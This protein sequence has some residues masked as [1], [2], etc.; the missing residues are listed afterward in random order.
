VER[1]GGAAVFRGRLPGIHTAKPPSTTGWWARGAADAGS[2]TWWLE[3]LDALGLDGFPDTL[4]HA[5]QEYAVY[6]HATPGERDDGVTLGVHVDQLPMPA[7]GCRSW[8]VDG[9]SAAG[10][11]DDA[12]AAQGLPPRLPAHRRRGG[13]LRRPVARPHRRRA[14]GVRWRVLDEVLA[15]RI[16]PSV[17]D[18]ERLPEPLV[19][20]I[21]VCDDEGGE[22]AMG[23]DVAVLK[24][25]LADRMRARFEAAANSE[26]ERGGM[27][28]WDGEELPES[29]MT[30]GGPAFPALVDDMMTKVEL[31]RLGAGGTSMDDLLLLAAEGA[32]ALV[33]PRSPQAFQE[34][35]GK[36]KSEW[37]RAAQETGVALEETVTSS[38]IIRTWIDK[39]RSDR[40]LTEIAED[41]E[42]QLLWLFRAR[43]AWRAGHE[44]LKD[45][46][47]RMRAMR[48]RIGRLDS[49]PIL[50]DLEKLERVKRL[51]T[52]WFLRWT[53]EPDDPALWE[54]GWLLDEWRISLFAPDVPVRGKVSEKRIAELCGGGW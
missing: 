37:F 13:W 48:S 15:L 36:A 11:N 20:K 10:R 52:P 43:F 17:F 8:G 2:A 26:V 50:K 1:G 3:D 30:P 40:N 21:W 38:H 16:E 46:P 28:A 4:E 49:L 39:H 22:L 5:G 35:A 9:D 19:T 31:G 27:H 23:C 25:A 51:W 53:A 6:Y 45:Y 33:F 12:L 47:R 7:R 24:L 14:A 32:A 44:R 41:M 18:L 54:T 42:E 34:M 29:V